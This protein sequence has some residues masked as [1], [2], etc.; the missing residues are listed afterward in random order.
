MFFFTQPNLLNDNDVLKSISAMPDNVIDII[1]L[2]NIDIKKYVSYNS[3]LLQTEPILKN[4][5]LT[6]V[7]RKILIDYAMERTKVLCEKE[8]EYLTILKK[9]I[10]KGDFTFISMYQELQMRCDMRREEGDLSDLHKV[11]F[12]ISEKKLVNG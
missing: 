2:Y 9:D 3:G 6:N 5:D 8:K 12:K 1:E 7:D 11:K 10:N 4:Y